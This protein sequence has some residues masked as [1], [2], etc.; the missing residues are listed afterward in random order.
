VAT[1]TANIV[2]V[3]DPELSTPDAGGLDTPEPLDSTT[4]TQIANPVTPTA[5]PTP[6]GMD[7]GTRT[8]IY[9]L[10]VD[11]LMG[12]RLPPVVYLA[13]YVGEGERLD[14]PNEQ[15]PLAAGLLTALARL[16]PG[17]KYEFLDFAQAI[18]PLDD[19]GT[20]IEGGLFITLGAVASDS[21]DNSRVKVR[22][23]WYRKNDEA[24]GMLY[25]LTQDA[26]ATDGWKIANTVQ[27]WAD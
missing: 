26:G 11:A 16:A 4:L 19:G 22:G 7:E 2:D 23:S 27:E 21:G 24:S 15:Q 6:A 10:V 1:A 17:P 9:A 3:G 25:T 12:E 14:S 18:G 8:T 13:P 5:V 20:V